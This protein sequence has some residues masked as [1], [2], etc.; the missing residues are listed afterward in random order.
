M[1]LL[2]T[3]QVEFHVGS[4]QDVT[5][6]KAWFLG[7]QNLY[8]DDMAT[9][10]GITDVTSTLGGQVPLHDIDQLL[11]HGVIRTVEVD[12]A[13]GNNKAVAQRQ[14]RYS[15][16]KSATIEADILGKKYNTGKDTSKL[17][18]TTVK[19]VIERRNKSFV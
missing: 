9:A 7:A 19:E 2:A 1:G 5:T 17:N 6:Q 10:T 8:K 11:L 16:L 18:G 4:G 3:L 15:G 13:N 14:I 12:L